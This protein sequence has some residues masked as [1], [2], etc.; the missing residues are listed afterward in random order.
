MVRLLRYILILNIALIIGINEL[1][2]AYLLIPMDNTQSNHLKAYGIAYWTLENEVEIDWLLNYRGGSFMIKYFQK[3]ENQ[4]ILRNGYTH[5][6]PPTIRLY[7][8]GRYM[9]EFL[10]PV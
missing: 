5:L 9:I 7:Y 3:L 6:H 2:A 8:R 1:H 4:E 10:F